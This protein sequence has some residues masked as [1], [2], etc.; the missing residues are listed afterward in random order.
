MKKKTGA[1]ID[2]LLSLIVNKQ[3]NDVKWLKYYLKQV[4]SNLSLNSW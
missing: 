1:Y 2:W 3:E 4:F